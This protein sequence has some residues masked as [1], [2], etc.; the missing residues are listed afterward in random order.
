MSPYLLLECSLFRQGEVYGVELS[1]NDPASQ[2]QMASVRD[3]AALD[4]AALRELLLDP[5]AYGRALAAQLFSQAAIKQRFLQVEVA[6][7]SS[8]RQIRFSLRI[9]PTA[10]ELHSVR[11]ECLRHPESGI[12][13]ATSERFLISRFIVSTDWRPVQLRA[14]TELRV[15]IAIAAPPAEDLAR[16]RLAPVDFAGEEKRI[17]AS[18]GSLQ[19]QV[20]GGAGAP[21]TADSLLAA[22]RD[23]VD[24]LYLVSHGAF[25]R[26]TGI[27]SLFLQGEDGKMKPTRGDELAGRM[28]ELVQGPRLVVLASCQSA[29]DGAEVEATG[30]GT[31]QSTIAARLADAGVPAVVAMQGQISMASIEVMMPVFFTELLKDGQIDR[32]LAVA[33]GTVRGRPDH[34]MPAL[35]LRL[36]GGKIWYNPGFDGGKGEQVW[37]RLLK[38]VREGKLVPILGTGLYERHCGTSFAAARALARKHH[39]PLAPTDWDDL[40]RVTQFL[41]VK[42]SRYNM[43]REAEDQLV[44]QTATLHRHWLPTELDGQSPKLG[45]L[46]NQ[47]ADHQRSTDPDDPFQIL[48]SLPAS[49]YIST[50]YDPTLSWALTAADRRPQ[51]AVSRWRYRRSPV[52]AAPLPG[53]ATQ[54]NPLVFHVFGAFGK[55]GD[56]TLVVS[57]DDYFDYLLA[58]AS[59]KLVPAE[60]ESALV[61]NSLLLLGF[62]L[63]DWSFRVLFRL[64]MSLP[65]RDRLKQYCH[66]AVQVD[67]DLQ[68]SSDLEGT[69]AYLAQYFG[70]EANVDIFWGSSREFL[71]QLRDEL[72]RSGTEVAPAAAQEADDWDF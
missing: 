1:H 54:K 4:V 56:D 35:F 33:R 61:D 64:I 45:K 16:V 66:V 11:W 13:L 21:C 72:K 41:S 63:T 31:V 3:L 28:A 68:H 26:S 69:K 43:I 49:V 34:W 32:A 57:E 25:A 36:T 62:R 30:R 71:I 51:A 6:A 12:A 15:L 17:R 50:T 22:L 18:L 2:A 58:S 27:P 59:G 14:Q 67:P 9:D 44:Q 23:G 42:E 39:F 8:N 5:D 52:P 55:D 7:Q 29:G 20:L 38:P 40:P 10:Q 46:L 48:A 19:P 53:D 37:K 47:V 65:G 60:V 24:I 70:Q